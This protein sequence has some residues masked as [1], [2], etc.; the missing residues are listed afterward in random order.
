MDGATPADLR[1]PPNG[2]PPAAEP[3]R[4]LDP[5]FLP[6]WNACV[7]R[8]VGRKEVKESFAAQAALKKEWDRLRQA[9]CWDE[10]TVQEWAGVSSAAARDGKKAHFGRIFEICVEKGSELPLGH[11]GRRY[12][13]R[14][15]FQG[16]QV[17]DESWNVAM[18]QELGSSPA[19]M[20]AGK[21]ADVY[22]LLEGNATEV[23]DAEQAYIQAQLLSDI[24]TWV[25]LPRE[26]QPPEWKGMKRPVCRLRLALYGHPDSGGYWEKHCEAHLA[27]AGSTPIPD[28]RSVFW[29]PTL[30]T[31][32][33]VYVGDFKLAGPEGSLRKAWALIR[34]G[35]KTEEPGP[36]AKY[37]GCEHHHGEVLVGPGQT[38]LDV[39]EAPPPRAGG[40][41]SQL[42]GLSRRGVR[43]QNPCSYAYIRHLWLPCVVRHQVPRALK[44]LS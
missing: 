10:S 19:T 44:K 32:L 12:K 23:A 13:G 25:E 15:V 17:V 24:P 27:K 21:A 1:V 7:A 5:D 39:L 9:G 37:L 8:P 36:L 38:P 35:I 34:A 43:C 3:H 29:H 18:F 22:G 2:V 6:P 31:M 41:P 40:T 30:R 11:A 16:N 26:R 42:S 20:T 4:P 33:V 28:W 14:V